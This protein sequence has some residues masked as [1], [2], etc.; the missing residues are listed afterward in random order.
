M[1]RP[2]TLEKIKRDLIVNI[3]ENLVFNQTQLLLMNGKEV[4][5]TKLDAF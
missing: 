2:R 4:A 5:L 1:V 3:P